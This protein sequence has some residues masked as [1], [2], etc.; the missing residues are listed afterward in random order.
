[1]SHNPNY[2]IQEKIEHDFVLI[3]IVIFFSFST[4][5]AAQ[6]DVKLIRWRSEEPLHLCVETCSRTGSPRKLIEIRA[7]PGRCGRAPINRNK[8][9]IT[10][11]PYPRVYESG[12]VRFR[13]VFSAAVLSHKLKMRQ[14]VHICICISSFFF[15]PR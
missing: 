2:C 4:K 1:M 5:K 3:S 6:R 13:F 11:K 12:T 10:V 15:L 9:V 7:K 8:F 14:H